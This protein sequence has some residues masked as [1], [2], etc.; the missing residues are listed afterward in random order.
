MKNT[1]IKMAD[2]PDLFAGN[3]IKSLKSAKNLLVYCWII[4]RR[5][6]RRCQ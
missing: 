6:Q 5:E 4:K 1:Y 2:R 3:K